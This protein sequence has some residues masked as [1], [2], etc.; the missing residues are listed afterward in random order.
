[1]RPS[2]YLSPAQYLL[3]KFLSK[4]FIKRIFY[5]LSFNE[6]PVNF[7]MVINQLAKNKTYKT[8]QKLINILVISKINNLLNNSGF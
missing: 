1:M 7:G 8:I 4:K 5:L 2:S 6:G 3:K